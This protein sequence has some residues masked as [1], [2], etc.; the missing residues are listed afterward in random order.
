MS[1]SNIM[2]L[3]WR[4]SL[5]ST[6]IMKA[7]E[8][9]FTDGDER[10][11][12][13]MIFSQSKAQ[14]IFN[15]EQ[16][17]GALMVIRRGRSYKRKVDNQP[18]YWAKLLDVAR[19]LYNMQVDRQALN[20][21][22]I[23]YKEVYPGM[24][25]S[26]P[27]VKIKMLDLA[28]TVGAHPAALGIVYEESGKVCL[29]NGVNIH[30]DQVTDTFKFNDRDRSRSKAPAGSSKKFIITVGEERPIPRSVTELKAIWSTQ[31]VKISA[32]IVVEHRNLA[33]IIT[34]HDF[35]MKDVIVVMT[36]G[37]PS[38]ATKEFLHM[39]SEDRNLVDK[40]FLYFGDHDM[41]GF[42]IFQ[43]IKY[44]S[45]S[46]AWASASMVCPRLQ[47]VGPT[48]QDLL[49]SVAAYEP[50]WRI[51]YRQAYPDASPQ[52]LWNAGLAWRKKME[53]KVRSKFA[54]HVPKDREVLQAFESIGW[55]AHE[56][57]AR[58]EIDLIMGD[59]KS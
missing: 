20:S 31:H 46:A 7:I 17:D 53:T 37:Y 38:G 55:M 58:R 29:P 10:G 18:Q 35:A 49:K 22:F 28:L 44:G 24:P 33:G 48:K 9:L 5:R 59:S 45:K 27:A 30:V 57:L 11:E 42:Q 16:Y 13:N 1:S 14:G 43:T 15:L 4:N 39:L 41:Q 12:M 50:Q 19:T 36:A 8:R 47:Y 34:H 21:R 54:K 3:D 2:N 52:E 6:D 56:P 32:V 25:G 23:E 40:P 51:A 26:L